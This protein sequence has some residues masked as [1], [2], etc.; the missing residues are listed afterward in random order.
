MVKFTRP[1]KFTKSNVEKMPKNKAIVY[2]LKN[3]AG[4]NLYTGVAGR[5]R[6]QNRLLEHKEVGKKVPGATYFQFAQSKT[7]KIAEKI[8]EQIIKKE[9]P[10]FNEQGK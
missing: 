1:R 10:K 3:A 2:K 6:V 5:G 9:Q 7:K 8:E 4:K